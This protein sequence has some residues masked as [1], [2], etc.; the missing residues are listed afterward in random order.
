MTVLLAADK[1]PAAKPNVL[2][3]LLTSSDWQGTYADNS[4]HIRRAVRGPRLGRSLA[5]PELM[6][7]TAVSAVSRGK[8]RLTQP[9]H[10]TCQLSL[11]A[12]PAAPERTDW[13]RSRSNPWDRPR[14]ER[15]T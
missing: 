1:P 14:G 6:G 4:D 15:R 5:R 3:V 2:I 12:A 10:S 13:C 9:W 8:T 7:A 11:G